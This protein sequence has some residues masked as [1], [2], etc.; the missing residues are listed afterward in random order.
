[1]KF[2]VD[3]SQAEVKPFASPGEYIVTVNSCK[4]DNLDKNGNPVCTLRY[5]GGN[6]EVIS[7]RFVLK[8][9]MMWRLQALIS[10]TEANIA[11][12]D[13]FDFSIGGA[14]FRFLQG[15]V[16]LQLVVVLEEEKY[17]DK[18]GAEQ[19]TLRV[20]RMKKVPVDVDDI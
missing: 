10:A 9:T 11:D 2:T 5:K 15:F 4:D 3:R 13:E 18:Q 7:D 17:T 16:G 8:D 14:F 19:V 6:G 20:K 1:M 12:G